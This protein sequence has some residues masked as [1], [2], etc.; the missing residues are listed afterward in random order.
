[1]GFTAI[2][3][4]F[5][6]LHNGHAHL[7][8]KAKELGDDLLLIMSGNFVERGEVT[9]LDKEVRARHAI[10]SG[11]DLVLELP[12]YFA[13]SSAQIF[14]KG[15]ISILN[16]LSVDKLIFGSECGN[17]DVLNEMVDLL[18][19]EKDDFKNQLKINLD[20][21]MLFAKARTSAIENLYGQSFAN[22]LTHPN[23][24]LGVEYIRALKSTNSNITP[25]TITREVNENLYLSSSKIRERIL[26]GDL[27]NVKAFLPKFAFDD[28]NDIKDK[29][30]VDEKIFTLLKFA[31][32][33]K[34]AKLLKNVA[35]M[36]EGLENRIIKGIMQEETL[37]DFLNFVKSKRYTMAKIKRIVFN[38]LLDFDSN[39]AKNAILSLD[40]VKALAVNKD[41]KHLLGLNSNLDIITNTKMLK[42]NIFYEAEKRADDLFR[43]LHDKK[44]PNVDTHKVHLV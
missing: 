17:I 31:L 13:L 15:A 20:S 29:A 22:M 7:I 30:A 14:A 21:G 25:L 8:S 3:C 37:G 2:I 38:I 6:P 35:E 36:T 24:I 23:N 9:I 28:L 5:N 1:M 10:L 18:D 39:L 12:P 11:A 19:E 4:E 34:P 16:E 41:K 32:A 33:N 42:N 27:E 40:H 26:C 43:I 44:I